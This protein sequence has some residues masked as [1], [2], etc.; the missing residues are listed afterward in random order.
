[1][2]RSPRVDKNGLRKGPWSKEE[3]DKL[4]SY[5]QRYGHWNW[6]EIPRFA[7][8]SRC[9]KSCRLRW[10]NYLRPNIKHGNFTKKEEDLI[11]EL[12]NKIGNKWAKIAAELPGRSDN[13]I[14][15]HWHTHLKKRVKNDQNDPKNMYH[16]TENQTNFVNNM[17]QSLDVEELEDLWVS[18]SS[19]E[20]SFVTHE[21]ACVTKSSPSPPPQPPLIPSATASSSSS[22]C[23]SSVELT[24]QTY[25]NENCCPD[26]SN[27]QQDLLDDGNFWTDPFFVDLDS[28]NNE[29]MAPEDSDEFTW[30]T[31]D[32]YPQY[33][34]QFLI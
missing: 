31:M 29:I 7:G 15:N 16:K 26:R 2:N 14:K 19:S 30:S 9:G 5:I 25:V 17:M 8:V 4:R 27:N 3:D 28:Y 34:S 18:S 11:M 22:S 10:M 32:F 33:H 12:H 20:L 21:Y 1:M 6:R 23:S 13:E 24:T